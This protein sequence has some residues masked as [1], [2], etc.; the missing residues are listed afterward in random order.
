MHVGMH[1]GTQFVFVCLSGF[2]LLVLLTHPEDLQRAPRGLMCFGRLRSHAA[3][4][5]HALC[6][7]GAVVRV[8][9]DRWA[10]MAVE[11]F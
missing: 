4:F 1:V 6:Q 8:D 5:L 11:L 9:L 10:L 3:H 2:H 7:Q